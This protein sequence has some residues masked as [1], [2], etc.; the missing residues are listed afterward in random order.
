MTEEEALER[1]PELEPEERERRRKL[2]EAASARHAQIIDPESGR[3]LFGGPQPGSGRPRKQR[4][5]ERVA[6]LAQGPRQKE[7]IDAL[8]AGLGKGNSSDTRRRTAE[9]IVRIEH[10]ERE[11]QMR[12]DEFSE[13]PKDEL[14]EYLI[15]LFAKLA[16][17]GELPDISALL[18]PGDAR[19]PFDAEADGV[20]EPVNA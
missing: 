4:V 11:L 19:L 9:A 14:L 6:E 17:R 20:T 13:K 18:P 10:Q 16:A 2:S 3:R 7:V 1:W 12:E 15:G 5:A 8:F